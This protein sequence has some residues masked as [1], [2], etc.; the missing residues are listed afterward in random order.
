MFI[1]CEGVFNFKDFIIERYRDILLLKVIIEIYMLIN[2]G[3]C[4]FLF[5]RG[6]V[7]FDVY[8]CI[9]LV[10]YVRGFIVNCILS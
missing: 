9:I 3:Y 6:L 7:S 5:S 10:R 4:V 2:Y 1:G 8:V